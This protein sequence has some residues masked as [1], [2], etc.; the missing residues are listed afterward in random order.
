[1]IMKLSQATILVAGVLAMGG[2]TLGKAST[3]AP[4]K[5][6]AADYQAAVP[7]APPASNIRTICYNEA[8]LKV[9]HARMVQQELV[10]A[11]LQCQVAGGS[12]RLRTAIR[13]LPEQVQY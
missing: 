10:V 4:A 6:A 13:R 7:P 11:T 8:D 2:C 12:P 1:M 9:M 3:T 5:A